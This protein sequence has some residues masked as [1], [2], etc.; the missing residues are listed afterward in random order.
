MPVEK[1]KV[2]PAKVVRPGKVELSSPV[3]YLKGVGPER[4]KALS[5]VGVE[6]VE[7][8]LY[9][10]PR[11]Y[12]DRSRVVKIG[13]LKVGEEVTVVGNV[14]D[15]RVVR[16]RTQ[17]FVVTLHDG[18]GYLALV[19]FHVPSFLPGYF[20]KGMEVAASGVVSLYG[21]LQMT[22][23]DFEI[24]GGPEE[25]KFLHT[26]R[27]IPLYPSTAGLKAKRLD[28]RGMRR[29]MFDLIDKH[30]ELFFDLWQKEELEK[31]SLPE[32]GWALKH[33]HFPETL[34]D[35]ERARNRL[36]FDELFALELV[37]LGRKRKLRLHPKERTF[38]PPGKLVEEFYSILPFKLT[39]AQNQALAEIFTDILS[40]YPMSRLLQGD[41]GSGK[42][43][44]A[45]A[46]MAFA[47]ENGYQAVLMA[48]TEVLAEQHFRTLSAW[49]S[50]LGIEAGLLTGSVKNAQREKLLAGLA[51][52][53][54]KLAVGTH[55]LLEPT[56]EFKELALVVVDEQHRFGVSQ[57]GLLKRKGREAELLAMTA[58][59]IPRSLALTAYGDLDMSVIKELPAGRAPITTAYRT[60]EKKPEIWNF[61]KT[62]LAKGRQAY[63]VYPV[64]EESEKSDL[65]AAKAEF[66]N[67]MKIFSEFSVGLL[68][69]KLKGN[70]KIKVMEGFSS[71]KL[72][73][74]VATSVVEVGLDVPNATLMI[75]EEAQRFGLAQLHQLRGRVGRGAEKSYCILISPPNISATAKAR[76][77]AL[78]KERDGFKIAELDLELRGPGEFL[79]LRQHGFP[80][81]KIAR[82]DDLELI[83]RARKKAE[84]V[85]FEK[86][87]P[88]SRFQNLLRRWGKT[89]TFLETS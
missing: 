28:S 74:L 35:A 8:F 50:K 88:V 20:E 60:E 73:L 37:L 45:A 64:I 33:V 13:D 32:L 18:T 15:V 83:H 87:E 5:E 71:G 19:W 30:S 21:T 1:K 7:D 62:E 63:V 24:V 68:H 52:G 49:Y 59:P 43:A 84:E 31:L 29:L 12:L 67:L 70:E 26:G 10:L 86:K 22:H 41:V 42:T 36:A 48:P 4:A 51:S 89:L 38:R 6:T 80:D 55:A 57:R 11:R 81:L 16:R 3:Q 47:V 61:V 34:E 9:Y 17:R 79:G 53:E 46:T 85:L 40:P 72:K 77:E 82:L 44:V 14:L 27:V 2:V 23:P 25:Q 58:T 66:E 76:L 78:T 69:G 65:K 56:V 54:L 75:V 39:A